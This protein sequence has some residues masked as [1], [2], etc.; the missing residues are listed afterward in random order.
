MWKDGKKWVYS[1]TYDE[2]LED[3]YKYAIPLHRRYGVPGHISLVASQVGVPRNV[4]G[5]SFHEEMILNRE[6]IDE[7]IA[8]GWGVSCHSMTHAGI[9]E[10]NARYE[11]VESRKVL[12][13]T[14][15]RE[16]R[17]FIVPGSNAS[18][19]ASRQVAEEAGYTSILTLWDAVN[20]PETE[21]LR[22]HRTP[23]IEEHFEPFF[24][25]FDPYCRLHQARDMGGWVIDYT[26]IARPRHE[27][28][29]PPKEISDTHLQQRFEKVLEVGGDDVWLADPNEVVDFLLQQQ[30][31]A[32]T[33]QAR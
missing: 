29:S 19:P 18:Y 9:N 5:S 7:L 6:Q 28:K 14:L 1:V 23:L 31:E 21:L 13:D 24:C 15:E 11:V 27:M 30:I 22:L 26:H 17:M 20:T 2:G 3:L 16:I 4:P 33:P 25:E 32:K 12:E 8:E 10:K